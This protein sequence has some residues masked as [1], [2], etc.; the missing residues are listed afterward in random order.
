MVDDHPRSTAKIAGHPLHPMLVPVPIAC[1]VGTFLTDI[2]YA[3]MDPRV[4]LQ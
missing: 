3:Y 2:A 4:R 1:F